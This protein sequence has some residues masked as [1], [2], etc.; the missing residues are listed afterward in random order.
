MAAAGRSIKNPGRKSLPF[1]HAGQN[2]RQH[3]RAE[4]AAFQASNAAPDR[5]PASD[6]FVRLVW[7]SRLETGVLL[8]Q[9]RR[10]D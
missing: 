8:V 10:R 5:V 9:L 4:T 3:L 1:H 7:K 2:K 6:R